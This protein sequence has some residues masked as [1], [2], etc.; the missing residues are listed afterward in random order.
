MKVQEF[1]NLLFE[2]EVNAH[3]AHLQTTGQGSF[4]KHSA[5]NTLYDDIVDLRDR[6]VESYQG[7]YEI[8]KGYKSIQVKEDIDFIEYLT[9]NCDRISLYRESLDEGY[10]QQICDD[11][12]ELINSTKYKLKYLR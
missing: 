4:A 5:L 11:I 10:L 3:I 12:L 7:Y 1:I 6:F 2:I 8:I 9:I